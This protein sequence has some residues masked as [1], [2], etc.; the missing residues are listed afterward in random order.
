MKDL[1]NLVYQAVQP[2][3]EGREHDGSYRG[4]GHHLAQEIT[5]AICKAIVTQQSA[6]KCTCYSMSY[7]YEGPYYLIRNDCPVHQGTLQQ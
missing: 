4:N 7:C 3:V 6:L 1:N 5:E 2:I